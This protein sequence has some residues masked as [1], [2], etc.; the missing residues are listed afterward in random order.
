MYFN[1]YANFIYF[2]NNDLS[3]KDDKYFFVRNFFWFSS[4]QS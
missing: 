4:E 2:Y 3:E 1:I